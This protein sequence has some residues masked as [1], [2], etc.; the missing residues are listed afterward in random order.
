MGQRWHNERYPVY[1]MAHVFGQV[2]SDW[3]RMLNR[4]ERRTARH[5]LKVA[6]MIDHHKKYV[7]RFQCWF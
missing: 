6:G 2:P 5:Q 4:C 1:S 7:S 3:R